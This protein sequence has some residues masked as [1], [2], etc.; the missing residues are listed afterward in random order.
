MQNMIHECLK[1][2]SALSCRN[3]ILRAPLMLSYAYLCT[4]TI[5]HKREEWSF[6]MRG[7]LRQYLTAHLAVQEM[8]K[9]VSH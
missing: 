4:Y 5:F 9:E 3:E 1:I 8:G 7:C 6:V 2:P